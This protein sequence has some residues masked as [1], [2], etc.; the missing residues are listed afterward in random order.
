MTRR[1]LSTVAARYT[2]WDGSQRLK[3]DADKV[4]EKLAEYLSYTDDVRQ[5]MDWMM[6]QGMDFDGVRVMGLEEFVE[7]LRQEMRQRY[8]DF[9]L[10]S[11]LSE[12]EQ[13]LDDILNR[14][15]AKLESLKGQKPGVEEKQRELSRM[16]RRLS[17]AMR[18]LESHEF[19]DAQAK[20]DFDELLKEYENIRDLENFRDRNQHMFHGPKSLGYNEALELMREMERMRQLEQDL[21]SGNFDTIS[22]EDL[23]QILGQQAGKDF[24]NLKQVMVLLTQSG[25]M[26]PKGDHFQLSPRGVQRIGQLALRDIYQNLL[27]DR[28][29]GHQ[30][31][32]RGITE[33]RPEQTKPYAFGD[34]LNLNLVATL[35]HALARKAGVPLELRPEDFEI[36]ENDYASSSSTVLCL[37]MSWSMSWEGRFAAAKKVAMAMETL[38]RSK[39]PRDYF[40]IVGFYTRAVEL[41]LKD[42]AEA[43][44]NMGDPFTNLQDGLRLASDLLGRHPSRNQHIIVITDG[45]PTAYF[46]NKRLYC[47]WPLSFGG[48]SMR[49]AQ[50]TLKEVERIT[51]KGITI[52]TFMLDDSPSLRAF[53]DKMTLINRGRALFT[54]PDRL[55]E[56]MLVD[57]LA[58]KRKRV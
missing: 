23:Q 56:Y 43:S 42:L 4:F 13:K 22:M 58:K 57:Y 50:E 47:E 49:A 51:R 8:R 53:V 36:Y 21:M 24:Q 33:M 30:T 6:R 35:K 48:I 54:R 44:W 12:M 18:K 14:E 10:K 9:N 17:E 34:P 28:S 15:R 7:Q 52:N 26:M 20:A 46:L 55:G 38:I 1:D 37:D 2:Q 31:D 32:H 19:E 40:A 29:G 25:Y 27:K 11:A 3:L 45:Q 16:P 41:K 5:A 39:F